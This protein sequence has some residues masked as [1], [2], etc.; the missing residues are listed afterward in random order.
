MKR[1]LIALLGAA[2]VF[3]LTVHAE[4]FTSKAKSTIS[5]SASGVT[6]S[7][8]LAPIAVVAQGTADTPATLGFGT[9]GNAFRDSDEALKITVS[10]NA[11]GNR[12]IIYTDN[13]SGTAS[14]QAAIDTGTGNDAGGLIGVSDHSLNVPVLWALNQTNT[15][16]GFTTATIGDDEVYVTDRAHVRTYVTAVPGQAKNGVLDNLA[17]KMCDATV[18]PPVSVTNTSNDGLYPQYFG[19][20]GQNL[21]VCSNAGSPVVINGVT[22]NPGDKIPQAEELS[23]NIAVVAFNFVGSTGTAPNLSTTADP[24]DTIAL[25]SPFYLPIGADFRTAPAQDY[26]TSTLTVELVTQ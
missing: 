10:S 23:K 19:A 21:D 15:N 18:T 3:S 6:D 8:S 4:A 5:V 13:L 9:G 22:I 11:A 14:P 1:I 7:S 17:T 16:Y 20:P 2:A 12:L 26:A 24:T 25:A